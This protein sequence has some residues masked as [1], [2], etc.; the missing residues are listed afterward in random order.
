MEH[1]RR[2]LPLLCL[3]RGIQGIPPEIFSPR[4]QA[5]LHPAHRDPPGEQPPQLPPGTPLQHGTVG[6]HKEAPGHFLVDDDRDRPHRGTR[7]EDAG[8]PPVH[9]RRRCGGGTQRRIGEHPL[10]LSVVAADREAPGRRCLPAVIGGAEGTIIERPGGV[11]V[12]AGF[13]SGGLFD[14]PIA[15]SQRRNR[16]RAVFGEGNK[17][18]PLPLSTNT[19]KKPRGWWAH[20]FFWVFVVVAQRLESFL[21]RCFCFERYERNRIETAP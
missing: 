3:R 2:D 5:V 13:D 19:R 4:R 8:G 6:G 11:R 17:S 15:P 21:G 10:P 18:T 20:P 1:V 12:R 16:T 7:Q 9:P 14:F